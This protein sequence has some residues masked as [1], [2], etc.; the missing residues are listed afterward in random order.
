MMSVK[1]SPLPPLDQEAAKQVRQSYAQSRLWF[2]HQ[3]E[4]QQVHHNVLVR[5]SLKG[6]ALDI[7]RA[8][9]ALGIFVQYHSVLRTSYSNTSSGPQQN[10]MPFKEPT[11]QTV[12]FSSLEK[13]NQEHELKQWFIKERKRPFDLS[14][15]PVFRPYI[16][17]L[18]EDRH[19]IGMVI[20]HI[21]FDG[22]SGEIFLL[23]LSEIY[24]TG[25]LKSPPLQ[26][27]DFAVW[28]SNIITPDFI[29][30]EINF[31]RDYLSG[32]PQLIQFSGRPQRE[33]EE[34]SALHQFTIATD[35]IKQFKRVS[36]KQTVYK[37]LLT[38]FGLWVSYISEQKRFLIG[39]DIH[40]RNHPDL[41]N[42]MGFF[43]NQMVIK[44]ELDDDMT[45]D[46][47]LLT[48][49]QSVKPALAHNQ[50][51]FD[52]LVSELNSERDSNRP[53]FYQVKFNYQ[54][55]RFVT[56]KF[57][58][59]DIVHTEVVQDLAN[60]DLVMDLVHGKE[61]ILVRLEYNRQLFSTEDIERLSDLWMDIILKFEDISG[62]TISETLKTLKQ[63]ENSLLLSR[64]QTAAISK[65]PKIKRS[66]RKPVTV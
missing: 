56:R 49:N 20:H 34:K 55:D 28:E 2:L 14:R 41:I 60:F 16:I 7:P 64:Q 36:K 57:G 19:E 39:T 27:A 15:G 33:A 43:V 24:A 13:A 47:A 65:R 44:H 29:T 21:A 58:N 30:Q 31:W 18:A 42:I 25:Q 26:Y 11:L 53:P 8:K 54:T 3:M 63:W 32:V 46:E 50:V 10:L 37:S 5:M 62:L 22:R 48:M 45:I 12:D 1:P 51:P 23:D 59:T 35:V 9:A 40:G 52:I 4:A 61:G 17:K 66:L 38:L 6:P